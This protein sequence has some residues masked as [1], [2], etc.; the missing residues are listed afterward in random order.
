MAKGRKVC[1]EEALE[2]LECW[3]RSGEPLST[4]CEARG[5]NWYS[6]SAYKGWLYTRWEEDEPHSDMVFTEVV[7]LEPT[8]VGPGGGR[9]R[10]E[11]G[12]VVVEVDD[13]FQDGT[14]RRL[15]QVLAC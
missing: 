8:A 2:L 5:L 13:A 10:I 11:L 4:W 14:L 6:L 3:E 12:E 9:Y 15:L 1:A 7:A